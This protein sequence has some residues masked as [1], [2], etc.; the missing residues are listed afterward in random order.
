MI[1]AAKCSS[2]NAEDEETVHIGAGLVVQESYIAFLKLSFGRKPSRFFRE[3]VF[4]SGLFKLEDIASS[5]LKGR[6]KDSPQSG[7]QPIPPNQFEALIGEY[8]T[9]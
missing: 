7:G 3:L 8:G 6:A 9:A 5:S 1:E 4:R 2:S